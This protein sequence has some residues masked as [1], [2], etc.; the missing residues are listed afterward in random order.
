MSYNN[1]EEYDAQVRAFQEKFPDFKPAKD[2][3]VLNLIM[4]RKNAKEILSGNKKV[5]Y[6]AVSDHY[7]GRLIDKD[8]VK[9]LEKHQDDEEVAK[10]QDEGIIDALRVVRKIH[11]HDYNNSWYLDCDVLVNDTC[12]VMKEDMD[13]LHEMYDSHDLDELYKTMELNKEKERPVFFTFVIDKVTDTN[14]K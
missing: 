4:T 8:V 2:I 5:E 13:A 7:V 1:K 11:F 6:R 3:E 12:I 9:F 14:L 10:A